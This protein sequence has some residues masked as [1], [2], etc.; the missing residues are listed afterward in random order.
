MIRHIDLK[1]V[2]WLGIKDRL[3]IESGLEEDDKRK[4]LW[5]YFDPNEN[6]LVSLAEADLGFR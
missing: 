4:E 5:L 2:D 1:D 6:G 3:P